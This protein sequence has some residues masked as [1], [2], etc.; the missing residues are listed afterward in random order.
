VNGLQTNVSIEEEKVTTK[1]SIFGIITSPTLQFERMKEKAPIGLPLVLVLLLMTLATTLVAYVSLDNPILNN[2]ELTGG[3]E[4][5]VGV[6]LGMAAGGALIGGLISFYIIA[7]LYR[8]AMMIM[9]NDT[10]YKKLLSIVIFSSMIS[11][12]GVL[13][14]GLIAFAVGG[15]EPN[16]TSLAPLFSDNPLLKSIGTNFDIFNIWYYVVLGLGLQI[17]AGLNKTKAI[18]LVI[19]VFL[20]GVGISSLSG[21]FAIPGM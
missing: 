17:V 15:Y 14:N 21:I 13:V 8:V 18:T 9:G 20:L 3:M 5:P 2:P 12:L 16:Y 19:I 7:G 6:T 1:P 11:T 4:I 10:N